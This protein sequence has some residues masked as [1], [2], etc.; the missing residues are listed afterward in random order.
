MSSSKFD[1]DVMGSNHGCAGV[2]AVYIGLSS[3]L[4]VAGD[5]CF[6]IVLLVVPASVCSERAYLQVTP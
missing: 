6:G 1:L 3:N 5:S 2:K 4:A